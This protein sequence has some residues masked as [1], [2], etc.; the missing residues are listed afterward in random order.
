MKIEQENPNLNQDILEQGMQ[1]GEQS[2]TPQEQMPQQQG[3]EQESMTPSGE[4]SLIN[5]MM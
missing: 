4:A 1:M 5:Q 2:Q 3:M